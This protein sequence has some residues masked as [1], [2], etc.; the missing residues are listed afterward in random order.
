MERITAQTQNDQLL[1]KYPC[2]SKT[3]IERG[4]PHLICEQHFWGTIEEL[5]QQ[6][7]VDASILVNILNYKRR[8]ID[9]KS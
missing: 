4:L 9:A 8:E 5:A 6:H 3:F 1:A 2:M 7:N